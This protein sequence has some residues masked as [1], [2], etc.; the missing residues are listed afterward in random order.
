M[1]PAPSPPFV[2]R[3]DCF[4]TKPPPA[5]RTYVL[6][7]FYSKEYKFAVDFCTNFSQGD[8]EYTFF[9][10]FYIFLSPFS[11]VRMV[12]TSKPFSFLHCLYISLP[13]GGGVLVFVSVDRVQRAAPWRPEPLPSACFRDASVAGEQLRSSRDA[14]LSWW[15]PGSRVPRGPVPT[16]PVLTGAAGVGTPACRRARPHGRRRPEAAFDRLGP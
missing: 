4:I 3:L 12:L 1:P 10:E 9:C 5:P 8:P 7:S 16:T 2:L 11:R 6:M 15:C 13:F 14:R